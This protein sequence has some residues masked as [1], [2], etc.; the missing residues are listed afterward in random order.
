[1]IPRLTGKRLLVLGAGHFQIPLIRRA[2]DLGCEV[3]TA[4]YLPDN[5]GHRLA[6]VALD[7]STVDME[8]VLRAAQDQRV[9]GVVTYGSDVSAPTVAYVAE[10]LGLPG[11]PFASGQLLQHKDRFRQLQHEL[12]LPHPPFTA[13]TEP[14]SLLAAVAARG[15]R[16]PLIVKPADSSGS[17]GQSVVDDPEELAAAFEH[18]RPFSRCGVVLAEELLEPEILELVGELWIRE[19]ELAFR[20]Y[21]HNHFRDDARIRVPVG[22]IVPGFFGPEVEEALDEQLQAIISSTH[23]R[24]GCMNFDA[25]V[26]RGQ[27]HVLDVGLRNG[28]N[29]LDDLIALSTGVDLTEAAICS[30]LGTPFECPHRGVAAPLPALSYLLT[31]DRE[32]R[33]GGLAIDD[34]LRPYLRREVVFCGLGAPVHAYLRGDHAL[35]LVLFL[36]PDDATLRRVLAALPDGVQVRV[37]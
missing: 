1:M 31:S 36:F 7:V 19:G 8:A 26:A 25:L 24:T 28:G 6:D 14:S 29:Y 20:Q 22:E 33:F 30:A 34:N 23:L 37:D 21:G 27:V 13:A 18:A 5:P 35:G 3:I 9:D 10:A 32:G 11:H 16:W 4:D 2:K 12:G 17:K 15:L